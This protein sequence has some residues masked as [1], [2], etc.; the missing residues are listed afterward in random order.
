MPTGKP[1]PLAL[2]LRG[3]VANTRVAESNGLM[4]VFEAV[5]NALQAV[6]EAKEATPGRIDIHIVREPTLADA[7]HPGK[8]IGFR[9]KDHGVGFTDE[10]YASFKCSDTTRKRSLGG[11]GV[12]RFTWLRVF[13]SVRIDSEFEV[14]GDRGKRSFV[15]SLDGVT[16]VDPQ[17]VGHRGTVLTLS[18]PELAYSDSLQTTAERLASVLVEHCLLSLLDASAPP[19]YVTD[20][21]SDAVVLRDYLNERFLS[22]RRT[23]E[24]DIE[25]IK[26]SQVHLLVRARKNSVHL[27]HLCAAKRSVKQIRLSDSLPEL[28]GPLTHSGDE[29]PV[30]YAGYVVSDLLDRRVHQDRDEFWL[31]QVYAEE[32]TDAPRL[33]TISQVDIEKKACEAAAT[34]LQ[35][36]LGPYRE[37]RKA[38]IAKFVQEE[39][40]QFRYIVAK[41]P[42]RAIAI[43]AGASKLDMYQHLSRIE[44][45]HD[46]DLQSRVGDALATID[47]SKSAEQHASEVEALLAEV[48][49]GAQAKLTKYVL[50]RRAVISILEKHQGL[51][52]DGRFQLE[53]TVH[54]TVFPMGRTSDNASPALWNLWLIDERLA[55]HRFLASDVPLNELKQVIQTDERDRPDIAVFKRPMG[56]TD[57]QEYPFGSIVLVDFKRPSRKQYSTDD[58]HEDPVL[59]VTDYMRKLLAGSAVKADGS[60]LRVPAGTPFYA[61]VIADLMPPLIDLLKGRGFLEMPDKGGYFQYNPAYCAYIEVMEYGKLI[62]DAKKRNRAF[63]DALNVPPV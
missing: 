6:D 23:S 24:F 10:N 31:G 18:E 27:V 50:Y 1:E 56:F 53:K 29:K 63:F 52:D 60:T 2:D 4:A 8:V 28:T 58:K 51:G 12:G 46:K 62:Q 40:P 57:S 26:F 54:Q 11:R 32:S 9:I 15:F 36:L 3:R 30:A 21:G 42:E 41:H 25:G 34:F 7:K 5:A 33:V 47:N 48:S 17:G 38:E 20:D 43:K 16:P 22:E 55:F 39:A 37:S 19:I 49:E 45:E 35:P 61:Y 59:Q 13:R 14:P 44:F